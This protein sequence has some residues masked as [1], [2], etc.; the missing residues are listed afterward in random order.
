MYFMSYLFLCMH[1]F[2][3]IRIEEVQQCIIR[4]DSLCG[5]LGEDADRS[6]MEELVT[7][8]ECMPLALTQAA[9]YLRR[10]GR[11]SPVRAYM[12]E[13]QASEVAQLS[14]LDRDFSDHRRDREATNPILKTW[15][16]SFD[17]IRTKRE[18]SAELLSMMCFC[19]RQA[20]PELLLRVRTDSG[21][22]CEETFQDDV[23]LLL[24]CT[25]ISLS[26]DGSAFDM[27]RLVQMATRR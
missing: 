16:I 18:T 10:R 8:L 7:L 15:Q 11:R 1:G 19:D 24:G 12:E 26:V 4:T 6:A 13:L 5:K 21:R 20:I 17:F 27:H 22:G 14:L 9:A 2:A 25:I 23:E 3:L